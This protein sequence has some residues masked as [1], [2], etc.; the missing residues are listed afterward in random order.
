M[1]LPSKS[2]QVVESKDYC[3]AAKELYSSFKVRDDI[4]HLFLRDF[5]G[6]LSGCQQV[7]GTALYAMPLRTASPLT[8]YFT[9]DG[10]I[11]VL[12][13]VALA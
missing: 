1:D 4:H 7:P 11:I 3:K 8:I 10:N 2:H 13:D 9:M 12:I 6:D 5:P